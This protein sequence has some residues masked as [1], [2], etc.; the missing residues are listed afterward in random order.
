MLLCLRFF[1]T[2][3][4]ASVYWDPFLGNVSG[5]A[6]RDARCDEEAGPTS[7][8][9]TFNE[10]IRSAD[11]LAGVVRRRSI[12]RDDGAQGSRPDWCKNIL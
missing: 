7:L 2:W 11:D 1:S 4:C 9:D 10:A 6:H 12:G 3:M 5:L 8:L